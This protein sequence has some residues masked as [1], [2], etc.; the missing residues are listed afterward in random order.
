M[1][2]SQCG[3]PTSGLPIEGKYGVL[4]LKGKGARERTVKLSRDLAI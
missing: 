2:R 3:A 1:P 4:L